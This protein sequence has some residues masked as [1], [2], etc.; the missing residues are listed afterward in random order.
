MY[1]VNGHYDRCCKES[2]KVFEKEKSMSWDM[3]K[4]DKV[5]PTM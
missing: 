1:V 5:L 2:L 3:E 4:S